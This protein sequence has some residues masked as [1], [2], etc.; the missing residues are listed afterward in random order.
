MVDMTAPFHMGVTVS[1]ITEA[2]ELYSA[3]GGVSW[4]S[5]QSMDIELLVEGRVVPTS[6]R[7]TYSVEG[8]V[9][10]ELCEGPTGSFWDPGAY[11]GKYHVGYWTEDLLGDL[12]ALTGAGWR[13]RYTGVGPDGGPAGFA[14]LIAPDRQQIE[15]VDV[16]LQAA[17]DNWYSGGDFAL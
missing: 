12:E 8:P 2:M 7:F 10:L 15:L 13:T 17:F 11:G 14:Y 5:L 3:A 16:V 6:V 4:H 1:N 9:Q